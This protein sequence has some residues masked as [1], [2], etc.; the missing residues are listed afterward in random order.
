MFKTKETAL[1]LDHRTQTLVIEDDSLVAGLVEIVL[2][3]EGCEATTCTEGNQAIAYLQTNTPDLILL[4]YNLPGPSGKQILDWID[5]E[6]RLQ[7]TNV[8][9]MSGEV[10]VRDKMIDRATALLFKPFDLD[11]LQEIIT[12]CK[13]PS[14]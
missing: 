3:Q 5:Q 13:L 6:S 12:A 14:A 7:N 10:T 8:V 9:I 1:Q 11:E 4:D 2:Q